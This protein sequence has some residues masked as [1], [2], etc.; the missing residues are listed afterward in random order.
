MS[1]SLIIFCVAHTL[2]ITIKFYGRP[3]QCTGI[4]LVYIYMFTFVLSLLFLEWLCS[5]CI[6]MVLK[7]TLEIKRT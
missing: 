4:N 1:M 6:I 2:C 5:Y 7:L 3:W